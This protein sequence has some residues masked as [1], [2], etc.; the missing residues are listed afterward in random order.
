MYGCVTE[1]RSVNLVLL[2]D[3]FQVVDRK[4]MHIMVKV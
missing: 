3:K 1:G 2:G 4:S